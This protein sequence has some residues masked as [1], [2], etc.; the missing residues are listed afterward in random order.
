MNTI[1]FW[2]DNYPR[3]TNLAVADELPSRA[4]IAVIGGGYTGL[5]AARTLAKS[6]TNTIVL[7]REYIGWG[8]SSRNGGITGC[9]LKKGIPAIFKDYGKEYGHKFWQA[10]LDSL[11]LVKELVE[12]EGIDCDFQQKGDLCVAYKPSHFEGFK[13]KLRGIE[14]ILVTNCNWSH[15]PKCPRKLVAT[16]ILAGCSTIMAWGYIQP[17]WCT[18]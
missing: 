16:P 12:E 8:A 2:N 7:E 6:G 18:V 4:D 3:P 15:P 5:S 13:K 10:G 9:G 1:S 14:K 17:N 11:D